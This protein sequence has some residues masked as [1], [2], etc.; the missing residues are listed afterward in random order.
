MGRRPSDIKTA[1]DG[2]HTRQQLRQE[3]VPPQSTH[4]QPNLGEQVTTDSRDVKQC[5]RHYC[6]CVGGGISLMEYIGSRDKQGREE[7]FKR[8]AVQF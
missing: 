8:W 3:E 7:S 4:T 2:R 6:M 5:V 1:M